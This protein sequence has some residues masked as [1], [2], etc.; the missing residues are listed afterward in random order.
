MADQHDLAEL[1]LA[2]A[3]DDEAAV[4]ALRDVGS[5]TDSI[6]GFHAQQAVE[7]S[8]KSVLASRGVEFPFSHELAGLMKLCGSAGAPVPPTLADARRLT[9]YG[10]RMRYGPRWRPTPTSGAAGEGR[11]HRRTWGL[12]RFGGW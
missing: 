8:L 5:V 2:K 12:L 9:P 6:V 11:P 4:R 10:A 3:T 1:L 7:K